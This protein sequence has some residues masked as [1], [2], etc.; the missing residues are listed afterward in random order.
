MGMKAIGKIASTKEITHM[1]RTIGI[2]IFAA[3]MGMALSNASAQSKSKATIPFNFRVGSALMPAGSYTIEYTQPRVVWFRNLDGHKS[4]VALAT[5]TS[6]DAVP[7]AKLV[8][9]RYG[10]QYFLSETRTSSNESEMTFAPSRLEKNI[11]SEEAI[12]R[13]EGQSLVALK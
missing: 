2:A 1:K 7:P 6:G 12:R 3:T 5:T 11:R 10:D 4:A 9:H 8:F 13:D